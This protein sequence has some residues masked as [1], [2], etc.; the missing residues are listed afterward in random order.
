MSSEILA[1][2]VLLAVIVIAG[3][4]IRLLRPRRREGP[5]SED[6]SAWHAQSTLPPEP[7]HHHTMN[8]PSSPH[9]SG[10]HSDGGSTH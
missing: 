7:S 3:F 10:T 2:V 4:V 5:A 8:F 9:D 1:L 6:S